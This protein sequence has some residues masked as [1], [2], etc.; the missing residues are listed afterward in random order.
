MLNMIITAHL[1]VLQKRTNKQIAKYAEESLPYHVGY[2]KLCHRVGYRGEAYKQLKLT[3]GSAYIHNMEDTI[4][5]A[6]FQR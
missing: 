2:Q 3:F 4:F 6:L 5:W 1:S